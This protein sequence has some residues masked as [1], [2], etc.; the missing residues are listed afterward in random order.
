M[1]TCPSCLL[2]LPDERFQN[3]INTSDLCEVCR[4]TRLIA[5]PGDGV[6]IIYTVEGTHIHVDPSDY[7]ELSTYSWTLNRTYGPTRKK[8]LFT[9]DPNHSMAQYILQ[10]TS[11][12][13]RRIK[14][15]DGNYKNLRKENLT[16]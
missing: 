10:D 1:K 4:H 16:V 11:K 5:I 7:A 15:K 6:S 12:L 13:W 14:F 9:N 3:R 8:Q 2:Q